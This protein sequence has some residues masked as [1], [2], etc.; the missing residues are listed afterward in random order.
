M[1]NSAEELDKCLAKYEEKITLCANL[2][3][4]ALSTSTATLMTA[5]DQ[6][7]ASK[8]IEKSAFLYIPNHAM[9]SQMQIKEKLT[10][11]SPTQEVVESSKSTESVIE[12]QRQVWSGLHLLACDDIK[13]C[14]PDVI[15]VSPLACHAEVIK[16]RDAVYKNI[17]AWYSSNIK[18]YNAL[19][20][21]V[22]N[23]ISTQKKQWK[24]SV[25]Q[26]KKL[27]EP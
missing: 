16:V 24:T 12:D 27:Y 15:A 3:I 9:I 25:A 6:I 22:E 2:Q 7:I 11:L 18:R 1:S 13:S 19:K 14:L 8:N 26:V 5:F 23:L 20:V 17:V 21:D 10:S 4:Q